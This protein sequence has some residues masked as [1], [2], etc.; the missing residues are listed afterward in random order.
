MSEGAV[1]PVLQLDYCLVGFGATSVARAPVLSQCCIE[2]GGP[3]PPPPP[4]SPKGSAFQCRRAMTLRLGGFDQEMECAEGRLR[5][6]EWLSASIAMGCRDWG[7]SDGRGLNSSLVGPDRARI[8]SDRDYFQRLRCTKGPVPSPCLIKPSSH[9][10]AGLRH[11]TLSRLL[12]GSRR[13]GL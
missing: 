9:S 10:K 2:T 12:Q 5:A 11:L 4:G 1:F 13:E 8:F 6:V 7:V 3:V